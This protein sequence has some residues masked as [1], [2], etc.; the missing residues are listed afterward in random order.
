MTYHKQ[1]VRKKMKTQKKTP[2][3]WVFLRKL[4]D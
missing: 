4:I 3:K 2:N 1:M